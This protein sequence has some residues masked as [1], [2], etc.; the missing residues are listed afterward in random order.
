MAPR[1]YLR[2]FCDI[3]AVPETLLCLGVEAMRRPADVVGRV[4][5]DARQPRHD[6]RDHGATPT[7]ECRRVTAAPAHVQLPAGM[8]PLSGGR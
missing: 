1:Y 7:T 2:H 3:S 8:L 6:Q 5:R 4:E